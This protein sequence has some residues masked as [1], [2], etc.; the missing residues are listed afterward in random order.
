[1]LFLVVETKSY[2][3]NSDSPQA[4]KT[5]LDY[6]KKF[7]EGLHKQLPDVEIRFKTRVNKHELSNILQEYQK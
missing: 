4:E 3:N 6:A 5:K 1:Q 2:K 7:F